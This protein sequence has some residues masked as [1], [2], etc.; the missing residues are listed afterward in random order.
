MVKKMK[1][2]V[3]STLFL[4]LGLIVC[5]ANP[6]SAVP[7]G[8]AFSYQGRLTEAESSADGLYDFQFKLYDN[9]TD[10]NQLGNTIGKNEV[11]VIDGY[12]TVELDFGSDAFDGD[13]RWLE[14]G[15][16]PGDFNGTGAY[17]ILSPR[18]RVTPT[19][20]A[21][22][23]KAAGTALDSY[24]GVVAPIVSYVRPDDIKLIL[25]LDDITEWTAY[26][27][28]ATADP[29]NCFCSRQMNTYTDGVSNNA[30]YS[31]K[32]TASGYSGGIEYDFGENAWQD[33]SRAVF[34]GR[35]YIHPG[36]GNSDPDPD[37]YSNPKRGLNKVKIYLFDAAQGISNK[38]LYSFR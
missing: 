17:T 4:A 35:F 37:D 2:R 14:I 34:V 10:G 26:R 33:F 11:N 32:V 18:Q 1:R 27:G 28:T 6:V 13:D 12:F 36:T 20:Y 3:L 8:T 16:Q 23:A 19:P 7:S 9:V 29:N 24:K 31:I 30:Q 38:Y 5:Q 25:P 22:Y 21:I 15:V